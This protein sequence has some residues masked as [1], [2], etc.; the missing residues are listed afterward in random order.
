MHGGLDDA[1]LRVQA[2]TRADV[3]DFSSNVNPLGA[4]R[5]ARRAAAKADL[6][7]YPDGGCLL[8]REALAERVGV[9]LEQL[10]IGNGSTELIHLLAR[11]RLRPGSRCLIFAPTFGEYAAAAGLAGADV[12]FFRASEADGFRWSMAAA[13]RAIETLR[14]AVV[15]LCN[16]NN[17][18][19][20]YLD[21]D[22][23]RH[24]STAVGPDGLLVLDASYAPLADDEWDATPLLSRWNVALLRSVTKD[25]GIAGVRLGYMAARL[26]IVE[27][28][29]R[30]QPAWSV[31]AVAQA[32]GIAALDDEAHVVAARRMIRES[33]AYL[34]E[35][36][37]AMD[38]PALPSVA[39]FVLAKVG[40]AA[41]VRR[42]LLR[43]RLVVRD[44]T[45]FG[46]PG[47]IRIAVRRPEECARLIAALRSVLAHA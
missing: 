6:S 18:T 8:L 14:P 38:V 40:D 13:V 36:L 34:H 27:A 35:Q 39:N 20:V 2:L 32:V 33:R 15:F 31:N 25:R 26:P 44:C 30:L 17:P 22:A 5:L 1:E 43:R 10:M 21:E 4:S 42:A 23:V 16:P 24:L 28:A 3:V 29:R 46:L 11:A 37:Q 12:K 45:S 47:Y 41:K 7:G 19:G 9:G